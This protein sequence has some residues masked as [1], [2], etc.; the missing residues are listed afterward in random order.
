MEQNSPNTFFVAPL[1]RLI[2]ELKTKH[3]EFVT[4][5][6][7][8]VWNL[9]ENRIRFPLMDDCKRSQ[10]TLRSGLTSQEFTRLQLIIR[11]L[12]HLFISI[13][14]N[15]D[16]K[17]FINFKAAWCFDFDKEITI[18]DV[19]RAIEDLKSFPMQMPDYLSPLVRLFEEIDTGIQ[20]SI[21][22]LPSSVWNLLEKCS[23]SVLTQNYPYVTQL[24]TN[25][26]SESRKKLLNIIEAVIDMY[27]NLEKGLSYSDSI[28]A[29][30]LLGGKLLVSDLD[31]A[32]KDLKHRI[33]QKPIPESAKVVPKK[34][35]EE[36][37]ILNETR[38]E[39]SIRVTYN[40][41]TSTYVFFRKR[42]GCGVDHFDF[43]AKEGLSYEEILENV[44][45]ASRE[46]KKQ[47]V[48]NAMF[49]EEF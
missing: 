29:G 1:D 34:E 20:N 39:N 40:K 15:K 42:D 35:D 45:K 33:A 6:P 4:E 49:N 14:E 28:P 3:S 43:K 48:I 2:E 11:E 47:L 37:V 17:T 24:R 32:L 23:G 26:S 13:E 18:L 41:S 31:N 5:L 19:Q 46:N 36:I 22:E 21:I 38:E 30:S 9:I 7:R 25:L 8:S 16:N 10:S 12:R 44:R 27:I